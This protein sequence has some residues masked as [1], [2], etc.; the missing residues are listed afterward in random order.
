MLETNGMASFADL[1][2]EEQAKLILQYINQQA[3]KAKAEQE[4][5]E[6]PI[7]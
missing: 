1:I 4:A 3:I 5:S 7:Q 2:S 6:A